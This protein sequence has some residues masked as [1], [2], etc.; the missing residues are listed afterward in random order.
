MKKFKIKIKR[1]PS[2][3]KHPEYIGQ[4]EIIGTNLGEYLVFKND[5][6]KNNLKNESYQIELLKHFVKKYG[7]RYGYLMYDEKGFKVKLGD[8]NTEGQQNA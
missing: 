2:F 4:I 6:I 8:L 5:T 1:H 7:L 3:F